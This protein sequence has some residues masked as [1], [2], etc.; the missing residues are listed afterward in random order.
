MTSTWTP[1][2]TTT[3]IFYGNWECVSAGNFM[4]CQEKSGIHQHQHYL[5]SFYWGFHPKS[6]LL[7]MSE[8][9]EMSRN[10]VGLQH[11]V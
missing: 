4:I 2:T 10:V 11:Y 9:P 6:L 3:S 7:G 1:S 5:F 8:V